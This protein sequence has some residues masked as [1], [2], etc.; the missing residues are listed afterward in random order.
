LLSGTEGGPLAALE[1]LDAVRRPLYAEVA[2]AVVDVDDRPP[3]GVAAAVAA[4]VAALCGRGGRSRAGG[5]AGRARKD[6]T[7][8]P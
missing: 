6:A 1:R 7:A 5:A 2:D 4:K 3:A 8:R